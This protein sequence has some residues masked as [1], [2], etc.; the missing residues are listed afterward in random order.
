VSDR[1][2][3]ESGPG[4]GWYA[5]PSGEFEWRWWSGVAWTTYTS[6][7]PGFVSNSTRLAQLAAEA[8]IVRLASWAALVLAIGML[9]GVAADW[10]IAGVFARDLHWFRQAMKQSQTTHGSATLPLPPT[11]SPGVLAWS[12]IAWPFTVGSEATLMI[13][14][15][16]SAKVAVS[17]GY[18][19][20]VSPGWG[21]AAWFIPVIALWMP[22][23]AVRGLVPEG[24]PTRRL[25]RYWWFS[26][27]LAVLL[28]MALLATLAFAHPVGVA[29]IA[30]EVISIVA[31]GVL[32]RAI[33]IG[34]GTAH[35][36]AS[37]ANPT[38]EGPAFGF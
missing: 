33:V 17:L 31:L 19:A 13:W 15:Y 37:A 21:V 34:V 24:H 23:L 30:P 14:Q 18:P 10:S 35:A 8:R 11:P 22:Y 5:D 16:R 25:M 20:V 26:V 1:G 28:G 6:A 12:W 4:P 36:A 29:L 3:P 7:K 27:V 2:V 9:L 38:P 32:T